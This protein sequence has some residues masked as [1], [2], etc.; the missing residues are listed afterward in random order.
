MFGT[1]GNKVKKIITFLQKNMSFGFLLIIVLIMPLVIGCWGNITE[2]IGEDVLT[3][4]GKSVIEIS[5]NST[6][7]PGERGEFTFPGNVEIN[8]SI[9]D[10]SLV[11]N[12]DVI[13]FP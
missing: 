2:L 12:F 8:I 13:S 1:R 4:L 11:F 7:I 5:V 9:R 10:I 3:K 6:V